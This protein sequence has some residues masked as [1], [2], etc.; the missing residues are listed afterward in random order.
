MNISTTFLN[1]LK[2]TASGIEGQRSPEILLGQLYNVSLENK[3][4]L[5]PLAG[6]EFRLSDPFYYEWNPFPS[7]LLLYTLEG[8]AALSTQGTEVVL[9]H[10]HLLFLDCTQGFSLRLL[11]GKWRFQMFFLSGLELSSYYSIFQS[12]FFCCYPIPIGSCV[13][14]RMQQLTKFPFTPTPAEQMQLHREL[15]GMFTELMLSALSVSRDARPVP[16]YLLSMKA[17]FDDNYAESHS[18]EYFE[19][20]FGIS[21]YRLC[22]EF[23]AAFHISPL[24]YLQEKKI[25][26]AKSLLL[27][28]DDPIH[29]VGSAVGIDNTNHFIHL[30]KKHTGVTP[31]VYRQNAPQSIRETRCPSIP[32][33]LP[34]Q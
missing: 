33:G 27:S 11:Q 25:E 22:R 29:E 23:S 15:T 34:P 16:A 4:F 31:F 24:Q 19:Q 14:Q 7:Y 5:L 21:R 28:T 6:G 13:S 32:G 18:L 2:R 12:N 20:T 30:F 8:S 26:A 10:E 1:A 17:D 3:G 9:D